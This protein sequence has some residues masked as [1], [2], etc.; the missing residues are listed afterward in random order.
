[1]TTTTSSYSTNYLHLKLFRTKSLGIHSGLV[2]GLQFCHAGTYL[3]TV[4]NA[5]RSL[6]RHSL[7]LNRSLSSKLNKRFLVY[8]ADNYSNVEAPPE[9]SSHPGPIPDGGADEGQFG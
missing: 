4:N 5:S 9:R 1:M 3:S 7:L 6:R 2:E 8:C